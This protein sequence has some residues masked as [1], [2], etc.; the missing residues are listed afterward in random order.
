MTCSYSSGYLERRYQSGSASTTQAAAPA[1]ASS[2]KD[3][4]TRYRIGD[5]SGGA[6]QGSHDA[7]H[8]G[9]ELVGR[10]RVDVREVRTPRLVA[11]RDE[12][13]LAVVLP[14]PAPRLAQLRGRRDDDDLVEPF[15]GSDLVQERHLR[16]AHCRRAG[17]GPQLLAPL[18][19][20]A[21]DERV[22][23]LLEEVERVSIL[24]DPYRD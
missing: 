11:V 13:C 8:P 15:V 4:T 9:V 6:G 24:E 5:A 17:Q 7:R 12:P 18:H 10:A 21:R 20:L 2:A 14:P 22:Q 3:S 1:N 23:K 16:H 19:V